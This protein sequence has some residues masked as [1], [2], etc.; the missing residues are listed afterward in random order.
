[1]RENREPFSVQRNKK[2]SCGG[3]ETKINSENRYQSEPVGG[4]GGKKVELFTRERVSG[5]K[6]G[7]VTVSQIFSFM[8][9]ITQ[10]IRLEIRNISLIN[11]LL[12]LLHATTYVPLPYIV[13]E[14][15]FYILHTIGGYSLVFPIK[16][17]LI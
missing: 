12:L 7:T 3:I 5:R 9:A 15:W 13:S 14:S 11:Y 17:E 2:L 4:T 6:Y 8:L 16:I 10:P 1:M